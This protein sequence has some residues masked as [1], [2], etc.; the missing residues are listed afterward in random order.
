MSWSHLQWHTPALPF[1]SSFAASPPAIFADRDPARDGSSKGSPTH[2]LPSPGEV[3]PLSDPVPDNGNALAS[4][5]WTPSRLRSTFSC[6]RHSIFSTVTI[7][8]GSLTSLRHN[9]LVQTLDLFCFEILSFSTWSSP[10]QGHIEG[11][12]KQCQ[13]SESST[14]INATDAPIPILEAAQRT[15]VTASTS[16]FG[17]FVFLLHHRRESR[18][19]SF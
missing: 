15:L 6:R 10:F 7:P 12:S 4:P 18:K 2:D 17:I 1:L 8:E 16:N 19:P 9:R 14:P 11:A 13:Q 3:T 5:P